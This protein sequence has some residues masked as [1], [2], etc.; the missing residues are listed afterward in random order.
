MRILNEITDEAALTL[1]DSASLVEDPP[2]SWTD[3][4]KRRQAA[5]FRRYAGHVR[6]IQ[7]E[8]YAA[9]LDHADRSCEDIKAKASEAEVVIARVNQALK[10][11][12]MT[13][14]E[15]RKQISAQVREIKG[16]R[17]RLEA[18]AIAREDAE[19][20][21]STDPADYQQGLLGRF[22]AMVG[23]LPRLTKEYL[24]NDDVESPFAP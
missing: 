10:T 23:A 21:L 13:A 3:K 2:A 15:G 1:A 9:A 5:W 19:R 17:G 18:I 14:D 11:G 24:D 8:R 7:S 4:Q 16:L 6:G 20:M 22:P 12:Q